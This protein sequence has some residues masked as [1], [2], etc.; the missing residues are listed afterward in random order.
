MRS[1][2]TLPSA[3]HIAHKGPRAATESALYGAPRGVIVQLGHCWTVFA[4]FVRVLFFAVVAISANVVAVIV[5][6]M[7]FASGRQLG[8]FY[9]QYN[10]NQHGTFQLII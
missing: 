1:A 8:K 2:T 4:G 3:E 7:I 9:C 10:T 6:A 5:K